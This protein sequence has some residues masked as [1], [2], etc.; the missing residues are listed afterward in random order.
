MGAGES[1]FMGLSIPELLVFLLVALALGM[2]K[3]G[4]GGLGLAVV[5]VMALL[6]GARES[7]G[8]ILPMLITADIM[9]VA[10]YRQHAVWKNITS[11]MPWVVVGIIAGLVTGRLINASQFRII[12]VSVVW[13]MMALMVISDIRRRQLSEGDNRWYYTA[14]LGMA[15]GFSTMIGN[16]AGPVFT[17]YFLSLHLKKNE[18]IGTGAWLYLIMNTG[19][20]PLQAIVWKN[21]NGEGLLLG[22]A[23]IPLIAS[24]IYLGIKLVKLFPE[25]VYRYFVIATTML[26]SLILLI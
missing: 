23:A 19:K 6:F 20:L 15:G 14:I 17:L 22:L 11:I 4:I 1:F 13:A 16:A 7:T 2:A 5:P 12:M 9:A 18:F 21:I 8:V 25:K 26:A 3:A 10:Y 24:G